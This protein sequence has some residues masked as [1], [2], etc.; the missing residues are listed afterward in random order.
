ME[1]NN[2][3]HPVPAWPTSMT[4]EE[5]L[6]R[7]TRASAFEQ[8]LSQLLVGTTWS[9]QHGSMF[10]DHQ[11]WYLA[12]LPELAYRK[13]VIMCLCYKPMAIDPLFWEIAGLNVDPVASMPF[14]NRTHFAV[15]ALQ[16]IAYIGK[17]VTSEEQLATLALEWT[18]DW[19]ERNESRLHTSDLLERLN[20]RS[21]LSADDRTLAV[22]LSILEGDLRTATT[23][24]RVAGLD[25]ESSEL[26]TG[27]SWIKKDGSRHS[28][29]A[30]TREWL[31]LKQQKQ[32]RLVD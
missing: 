20:H 8:A 23:L 25:G 19:F 22:Y 21:P 29:L 16:C 30:K 10:K 3:A 5:Q 31:A 15:P 13:G 28:I 26:G 12:N 32:L 2:I 27:L 18:D 14:R 11:G 24:T 9:Y 17:D 1:L 7:E 4:H 6:L